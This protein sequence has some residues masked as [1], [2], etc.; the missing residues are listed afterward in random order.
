MAHLLE[1]MVF[2]GTPR[3]P[4][5]PQEQP[6]TAPGPTARPHTT[7]NYYE[8]MDATEENL[9]WAL[10]LKPIAWSIRSCPERPGERVHRRAQRV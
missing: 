4:N 3:H 1:H 5:I 8:T 7:T 9:R 2:K 10:D 6:N